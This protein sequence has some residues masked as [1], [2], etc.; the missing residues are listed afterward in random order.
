MEGIVIA[1]ALLGL[2]MGIFN[3]GKSSVENDVKSHQEFI[4][5]HS[6]YKCQLVNTLKEG[7]K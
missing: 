2:E 1:M 5:G 3:L 6:S 4:I 7:E